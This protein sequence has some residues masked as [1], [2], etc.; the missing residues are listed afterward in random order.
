VMLP[1]DTA[2][3]LLGTGTDLDG[4][5]A[6]SN[7]LARAL[8]GSPTVRECMARQLFRASTGRGVGSGPGAENKFVTVWRQL[9]AD[10]QS[11][12]LETLVAWVR[13]DGF[14]ARSTGP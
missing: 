2:T 10:K 8:A 1:V 13:S 3:S 6:D 9:P 11:S 14:V 7:A 12:L 4:D 5:Y